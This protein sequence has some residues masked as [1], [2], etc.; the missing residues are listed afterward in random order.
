MASGHSKALLDVLSQEQTMD[1][2]GSAP[3]ALQSS[4]GRTLAGADEGDRRLPLAALRRH[5]H[6]ADARARAQPAVRKSSTRQVAAAL[7]PGRP[8]L[9]YSVD[10]KLGGVNIG[11]RLAA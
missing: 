11:G 6:E 9:L 5:D 3:G 1:I 4:L 2:G 8:P 7:F 10:A